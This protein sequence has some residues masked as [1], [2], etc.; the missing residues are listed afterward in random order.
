MGQHDQSPQRQRHPEAKRIG[1][2]AAV[3]IVA[4]QGLQDRRRA[5]KH[6]GDQA[7]LPERQRQFALQHRIDRRDQRLHQIIQHMAKGDCR[8]D[9]Q[10]GRLG[11]QGGIG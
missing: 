5:L 10:N 4:D 6:E 8:D 2:G 7:D 1:Q 9:R 3:G 11:P